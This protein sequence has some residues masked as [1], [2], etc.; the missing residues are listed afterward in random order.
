MPPI[1]ARVVNERALEV[2]AL[3]VGLPFLLEDRACQSQRFLVACGREIVDF[4]KN[5][6][7]AVELLSGWQVGI[8]IRA[9]GVLLSQPDALFVALPHSAGAGEHLARIA[10]IT[11]VFFN[12]FASDTISSKGILCPPSTARARATFS[13]VRRSS[14][15]LKWRSTA[16]GAAGY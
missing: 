6:Q 12:H 14:P 8:F 10:E 15:L 16:A 5:L 4:L 13:L 9:Q 7:C 11:G 3:A 1:A 2:E